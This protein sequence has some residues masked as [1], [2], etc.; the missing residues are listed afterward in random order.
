[1][2]FPP[3][4]FKPAS[5]RAEGLGHADELNFEST[6]DSIEALERT[7]DPILDSIKLLEKEKTKEEAALKEDYKTLTTL[8][9]NAR[10]EARVWKD[11]GRKAHPFAPGKGEIQ[12]EESSRLRLARP[13][14]EAP[15]NGVFHVSTSTTVDNVDT[16]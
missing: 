7:L 2:P 13:R 6:V 4:T 15:P 5:R 14:P 12:V 3:P 16:C 1:M 9:A 11:R 8:E 10:S